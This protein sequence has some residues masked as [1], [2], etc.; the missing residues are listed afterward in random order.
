MVHN[1]RRH[2]HRAPPLFNSG[3]GLVAKAAVRVGI[4]HVGSS[5][6]PPYNWPNSCC[7][8]AI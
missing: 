2:F 1:Q 7:C 4:A 6:G 5:T 8:A 3:L